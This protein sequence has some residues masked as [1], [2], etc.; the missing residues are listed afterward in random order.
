MVRHTD[1]AKGWIKE[2]LLQFQQLIF[3]KFSEFIA[4]DKELSDD[5]KKVFERKIKDFNEKGL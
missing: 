1:Q 2:T 3:T 5:E 4:S